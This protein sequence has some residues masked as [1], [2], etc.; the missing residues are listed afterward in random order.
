MLNM[1]INFFMNESKTNL[2]ENLSHLL[3][4]QNSLLFSILYKSRLSLVIQ[5][6]EVCH[7]HVKTIF[8]I[9]LSCIF[10]LLTYTNWLHQLIARS[11]RMQ[12]TLSS[13]TP[14]YSTF[15]LE[16]LVMKTFLCKAILPLLLIQE[17]QL[18]V[19]G[20]KCTLSTG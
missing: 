6:V 17:E 15:F 3:N 7:L 14:M 16:D 20:K 19:N 1:K 18:S 9:N 5:F 11:P 4:H 12:V 10:I 2:G 13:K 8:C